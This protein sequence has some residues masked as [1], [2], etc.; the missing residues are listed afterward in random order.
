MGEMMSRLGLYRF[1]PWSM[2]KGCENKRTVRRSDKNKSLAVYL[3]RT[4]HD[5][6]W[7]EAMMISMEQYKTRRKIKVVM[8]RQSFPCM[9]MAQGMNLDPIP[10]YIQ[11]L[12]NFYLY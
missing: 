7:E 11:F 4:M 6:T 2:S 3:Q 8:L 9:N 5:I 1:I 12:N 10:H